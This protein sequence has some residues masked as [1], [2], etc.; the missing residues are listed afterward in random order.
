MSMKPILFNTEMVLANLEDRKT[1]T[2]RLVK[3]Q[4]DI[5]G[6]VRFDDTRFVDT[7]GR[8]YKPPYQTGDILYVRETW[9][10]CPDLFGEFPEYIYRADYAENDLRMGDDTTEVYS[11]F[12][13][14]VKWRPSIHMPKEAARLFLLVTDVRVERLQ[15]IDDEGAKAEGANW[16]NGKNV[17]LEE[18][19]RRSAVERFAEI[20]DSTIK[21]ADLEK[22]G[23]NANPWVWV[24]E[25]ERISKEDAGESDESM[26]CQKNG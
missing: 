13:A 22:Y 4:P 3:P 10:Q 25:Y 17:G 23:W 21:L 20:W 5:D 18:K 24:F 2:R 8:L 26:A 6:L 12:P 14:C 9:A 11:D 19:M 15:D 16:H 7:D 1:N